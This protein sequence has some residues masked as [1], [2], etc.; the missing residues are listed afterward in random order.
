MARINNVQLADPGVAFTFVINAGDIPQGSSLSD[1][2]VSV[3][4]SGDDITSG[5]VTAS[6]SYNNIANPLTGSS[7]S[8]VG[9]VFILP[10]GDSPYN[11]G[12]TMNVSVSVTS[13][14]VPSLNGTYTPSTPP[15][16]Q[17]GI[18]TYTG[19]GTVL[20]LLNRVARFVG[21]R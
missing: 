1:L 20:N 7:T 8:P 3:T 18:F 9:L 11:V 16:T 5:S 6:A 21:L 2:S 12:V 17:S 10:F 13:Q 15:I 19:G 4:I 14:S